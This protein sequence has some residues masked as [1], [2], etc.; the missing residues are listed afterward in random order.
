MRFHKIFGL[1]I[2]KHHQ[3]DKKSCW[4]VLGGF[5]GCGGSELAMG[6]WTVGEWTVHCSG[7][8]ESGC[9]ELSK[10]IWFYGLKHHTVDLLSCSVDPD[11]SC[12][13]TD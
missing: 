3:V 2:V 8:V 4:W 10:N 1:Y 7:S 6:E 5:C 13:R 11:F 9:H 12:G